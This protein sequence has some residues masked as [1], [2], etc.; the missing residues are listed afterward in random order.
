MPQRRPE[1]DPGG[2]RMLQAPAIPSGNFR[3]LRLVRDSE[4]LHSRAWAKRRE[5]RWCH[6]I[7]GRRLPVPHLPGT[8]SLP[9]AHCVA[10]QDG[11]AAFPTVAAA[12]TLMVFSDSEE[13]EAKLWCRGVV[14]RARG[15]A[16]RQRMCSLAASCRS[17]PPSHRP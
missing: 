16:L 3:P 2:R 17:S 15:D 8:P 9:C 4:V 13:K 7:D 10:L 1:N 14:L 5:I 11:G 12:S 6:D